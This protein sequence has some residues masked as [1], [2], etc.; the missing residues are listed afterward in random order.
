MGSFLRV[1]YPSYM[2]YLRRH[3]PDFTSL[4]FAIIT[5]L[6]LASVTLNI[7]FVTPPPSMVAAR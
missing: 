3:R 4:L 7:E 1:E 2:S 5:S 6:L